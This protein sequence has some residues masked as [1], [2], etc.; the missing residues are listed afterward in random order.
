MTRVKRAA[1]CLL[2]A[3]VT[4]AVFWKFLFFGS[5]L[6]A[7]SAL[8]AQL[9]KTPQEPSG[10]FKS[11]YRHTR[12][13]DNLA[14]LAMHL[15]IYNEGLHEN[16]LALWN[17][18]LFCGLPTTADPMIHPFYPPNMLLHRVWGPD[19]AY[20]LGAMLH[21][22]FSGVSMHLLLRSR[23][24]TILGATVGAL[25]WMLGGYNAMW[26]STT[27]LA[28]VSVFGP[29]ALM[30][31]LKGVDDKD[32]RKASLAGG[33]MGL[34]VLGSHPQH[35]LLFFL[36]LL[37]WT[38]VA[39][40]R[41]G[42][43]RLFAFRFVSRF[44]LLTVG[45]GIV[46]V[47]ARLDSIENGYRDPQF[48]TLSLYSEPGRLLTHVSGLILGKVY[49]PGPGFEA[50]FPI[51]M[52]LGA[53]ALA[54]VAAIRHWRDSD[55]RVA[56][57]CVVV[58]L[59]FAF[60][61]PLAWI[62]SKLPLLGLS[63]ASRCLF[64]AGFGL[65]FL[66][67]Q[68]LDDLAAAPGKVWRGVAWVAAVFLLAALIGFDPVKLSN[69]A[70]LETLIGFALASGAAFVA[71]RHRPAAG[72][73]ALAAIL[74]ELLPPFIQQNYHSDSSLLQQTPLDLPIA[75]WK[76]EH[77]RATGVLGTTALTN[78][79]EQWGSDLVTGNNLLALFGAPNVGGFEAIIPR[80]Y[81]SFAQSAGASLSPAGRT[82][83][84]TKLDSPLLDIVALKY[85]LLPPGLKLPSR[86]KAVQDYGSVRLHA[87]DGALPRARFVSK[88]FKVRDSD[89]AELM[90]HAPQFNPRWE[91]IFE[92][93][94]DLPITFD[95]EVTLEQDRSDEVA[96]RVT[97]KSPGMLL[98]A[99]TNYPGWLA[100]IDGNLVPILNANAAF[101][102]VEVPAGSHRVTF[103]Y[104][105]SWARN[106]LWGSVF[107]MALAAGLS[108]WRG[109]TS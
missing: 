107:F 93:D 17:P 23:G 96:L 24:R 63:P 84:F 109:R 15:R 86:Y 100:S 47:L 36:L 56:T 75:H 26:F 72:A 70:A 54:T 40:W 3:A 95:G 89:E 104:R 68:G 16:R 78:K 7:M 28:G 33:A 12:V 92:T 21:L 50:E 52:G 85:V 101:R 42:A 73:L 1:P 25:V 88:V 80:S 5:T 71:L 74:F 62:F 60:A 11:E 6:Y 58:G 45:V 51:Y 13:S 97:T 94:R 18:Y 29:L 91:T 106:G 34:A 55:A 105:P 79:S 81:V 27:I 59:A 19:T 108:A 77:V 44:A 22:F 87:N 35:A 20:Q 64:L 38:G 90:V 10:W 57:I 37:A 49:F 4:V 46:E 61:Y 76:Q 83:Q 102:A 31:L 30:A 8:E 53:V 69:G 67:G 14:L 99:D 66:A 41:S 65:A 32:P 82:L 2:F 48:D 39:L 43:E 9:G 98:L 103:E